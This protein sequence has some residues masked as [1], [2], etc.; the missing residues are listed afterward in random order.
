MSDYYADQLAN[1]SEQLSLRA[2]N[3]FNVVL[4]WMDERSEGT[5]PDNAKCKALMGLSPSP[6]R[7][8]LPIHH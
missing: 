6:P 8:T 1:V 5:P 7:Q 2:F 3:D 4:H